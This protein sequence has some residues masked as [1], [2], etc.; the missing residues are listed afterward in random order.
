MMVVNIVPKLPSN[1]QIHHVIIGFIIYV[2]IN[3]MN[4]KEVF[5]SQVIMVIRDLITKRFLFLG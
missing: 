2:K 3:M 1:V 4:I 5:Y